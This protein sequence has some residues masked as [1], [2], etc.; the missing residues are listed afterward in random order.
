[1]DAAGGELGEAA[2][3]LLQ[4]AVGFVEAGGQARLEAPAD[5]LEEDALGP[6][7]EEYAALGAALHS[8]AATAAELE[9]LADDLLK[10][11]VVVGQID[12]L[13]NAMA[14]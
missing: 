9:P 2:Q 3:D 4:E 11:K 12:K 7:G 8:A 13:L 10:C 5:T 1:V 14:E 6:L